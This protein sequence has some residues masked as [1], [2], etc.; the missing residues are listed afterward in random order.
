MDEEDSG[1]ESEHEAQINV[2]GENQIPA[3]NTS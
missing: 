2:M 3:G 1:K